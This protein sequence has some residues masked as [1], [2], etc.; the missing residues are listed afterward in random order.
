MIS[1]KF[2]ALFLNMNMFSFTIQ[3]DEHV[4]H[5]EPLSLSFFGVSAVRN[6]ITIAKMSD[7]SSVPDNF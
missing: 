3:S 7:T 6:R 4:N 5:F 1:T 2:A